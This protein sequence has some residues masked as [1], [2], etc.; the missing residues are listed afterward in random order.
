[1]QTRV[2]PLD[3]NLKI[4]ASS[5][6]SKSELTQHRQLIGSLIYLT[7]TRP[8]LGYSVGLLS[9]FMQN[10]RNLHLDCAKRM[11]RYVSTTMDYDTCISRNDYST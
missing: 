3:H 1:M 11:L 9:Q 6:T 2:S 4:D 10:Q 7:I 5:G 8:D